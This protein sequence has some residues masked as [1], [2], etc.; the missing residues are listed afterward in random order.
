MLASYTRGARERLLGLLED[1]GLKAHKL[2]ESWQE[3]LG[4]EDPAG[5]DRP[6][7]GA[8]VHH[9]RCRGSYRA[10]PARRPPRPAAQED[11]RTQTPSLPELA[12][13]S[14]GDLVVHA[15]HGIGR[16]VGLTQIPVGS[17]AR[18]RALEYAGATSC[19]FR[20]RTSTCFPATAAERGR[21]PRP[22]R[23]RRLGSGARRGSRSASA[24]SPVSCIT[25]PRALARR[26]GASSP[27]PIAPSPSSSTA[28]PGRRP[29]TRNARSRTCCSDL[30]PGK[31]MD[32]LVC[33]DVGFGKTEVAL[34]RRFRH[35][36]ER[37]GRSRS[38]PDHAARAPALPEL[39]RALR[40]LSA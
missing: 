13:L 24:R 23:R 12:A 2:V 9:A 10:G 16:Y 1:H 15:D 11:G 32:R 39:R 36:D 21:E 4:S 14:P 5:A 28:S 29:T 3:A 18:L 17:A 35:G 26:A 7:A 19:T 31:P 40:R 22:A 27:S 38:S 37:A 20:S 25:P 6:S 30:G 34:A 33:G 8:R